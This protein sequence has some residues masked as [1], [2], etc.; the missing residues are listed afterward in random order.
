[1]VWL[2]AKLPGIF[3][4]AVKWNFTKFLIGLDGTPLHRFAPLTRPEKIEEVIRQ[5][6]GV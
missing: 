4:R 5:A 6:L 1:L 2:T 3:G